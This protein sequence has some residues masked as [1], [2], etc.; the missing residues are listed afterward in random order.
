MSG[1]RKTGPRLDN[2]RVRD[3][4]GGKPLQVGEKFV[5]DRNR[6][7]SG[8]R[9]QKPRKFCDESPLKVV[10]NQNN[11]IKNA[12][13]KLQRDNS[14]RIDVD[15]VSAAQ[16]QAIQPDGNCAS[17]KQLA[18]DTKMQ[19][20]HLT[21]LAN[22]ID[23]NSRIIDRQRD[24]VSLIA[25][26]GRRATDDDLN[27]LVDFSNKTSLQRGRNPYQELEEESRVPLSELLKKFHR[28]Y[29]RMLFCYPHGNS[30]SF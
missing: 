25:P 9:S 16:A 20:D 24:N 18:W 6:N 2:L 7:G 15:T 11:A 14:K 23:Q 5:H 4:G 21:I 1:G 19:Q 17:S 12:Y 3:E 30:N 13:M 28:L 27:M 29:V 10:T 26:S 8:A 22:E